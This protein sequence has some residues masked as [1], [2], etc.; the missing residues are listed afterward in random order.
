MDGISSQRIIGLGHDLQHI[1]ELEVKS[2]LR[3][4][5]VF[6]TIGEHS[7]ARQKSGRT[8]TEAGIYCAKESFYKSLTERVD[9]YWTDLEV[10][11]NKLNAP[12]FEYH[13]KLKQYMQSKKLSTRLSI[14]HSG[15]YASAYVCLLQE[16]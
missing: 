1:Q 9:F 7:Y 8:S 5:D 6:F 14:S 3:E 16:N 13:G 10:K 15:E 2:Y 12:Y 11:H 4:P